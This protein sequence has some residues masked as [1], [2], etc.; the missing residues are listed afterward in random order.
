MRKILAFV[1][2]LLILAT[3]LFSISASAEGISENQDSY[4][5]TYWQESV[6]APAGYTFEKII[7]GKDI[8]V[9]SLKEPSDFVVLDSKAEL[10]ILDS[11]NGRVVVADTDYKVLRELNDFT[12]GDEKLDIKG[13]E[14]IYVNEEKIVIADTLNSR[15]IVSDHDGNVS[16]IL[17]KPVAASYGEETVFNPTKVVMDTAGNFYVVCKGVYKGAVVYDPKGNYVGFYGSNDVT[18]T[19]KVIANAFWK[20]ILNEEQTSQMISA[21]PVEFSNLDI[22]N[23]GFIYSSTKSD[24][25]NRKKTI[26]KLNFA[27]DNVLKADAAPVANKFGT[28]DFDI[29]TVFSDTQFSDVNIAPD[30][31]ISALDSVS[32][33]VYQY[34]QDG[35]F[36]GVFAG[37]GKYA[38]SFVAPTA[39]E[40]FG[41]KYAV[42]DKT[43]NTITVFTKTDYG[44][45]LFEA[46]ALYNNG[47]YEQSYN[48]WEE[49]LKKNSNCEVAY[50][51]MADALYSL[52]RAEESLKY[53]KLAYDQEGYSEAFE[54]VRGDFLK[55][56]FGLLMIILAALC[57]SP[58]VLM[59]VKRKNKI[60]SKQVLVD[61]APWKYPFRMMIH[62]ADS[63]QDMRYLK[64][65][66][67]SVAFVILFVWYVA[68]V[69][70]EQLS[71]FLFNLNPIGNVNILLIFLSTVGI[72]FV[73]TIANWSISTLTDGEGNYK[74]IF[75]VC[76]YALI[77]AII[78]M[79]VSTLLSNVLVLEEAIF[80]D[81][82]YWIANG[83][84]IVL[85]VIGLKYEHQYEGKNTILNFVFS[86]VGLLLI[87]F[88]I[89]LLFSL[90]QQ[91]YVFV[92]TVFFEISIRNYV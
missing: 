20:K 84:S 78:G 28:L 55:D 74:Q 45:L 4:L 53:Y 42:L 38:G 72:F 76:S 18:L 73:F 40:F 35:R 26:R 19:I 66:R 48:L 56:N 63:C 6:D 85:M 14:G 2:V 67:Y 71:G 51:G 80:V 81:W 86:V 31:I 15:V 64:K 68:A 77:P 46:I 44:K 87:L 36:V 83:Y 54:K 7:D 10:Y 24:S 5:Y 25:E 47:K 1:T 3:S 21:V 30:G 92:R 82:I 34:D 39:I 52:G 33:Q 11:G 70:K 49:I 89:L 69:L 75:T 61:R 79:L 65:E 9:E 27:G 12:N 41:G 22:D 43:K 88:L 23:N 8:G 13:A 62:P 17:T 57:I 60:D 50:G 32:G 58:F 29:D 16:M 91:F 37:L 90:M 59:R